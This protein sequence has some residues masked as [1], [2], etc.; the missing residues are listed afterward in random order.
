MWTLCNCELTCSQL[1]GHSSET[2]RGINMELLQETS[3]NSAN[4][5]TNMSMHTFTNSYFVSV[6][7]SRLWWKKY[8]HTYI[9]KFTIKQNSAKYKIKLVKHVAIKNWGN[10]MIIFLIIINNKCKIKLQM[11]LSII[12]SSIDSIDCREF[13]LGLTSVVQFDV[14]SLKI[15]LLFTFFL[16]KTLIS[17]SSFL[18]ML[19]HE[20]IEFKLKADFVEASTLFLFEDCLELSVSKIGSIFGKSF[21]SLWEGRFAE[22]LKSVSGFEAIIALAPF[23]K[24]L[25]GSRHVGQKYFLRTY[26]L[27]YTMFS[28]W[29]LMK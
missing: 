19:F 10:K 9:Y 4:T 11:A 1:W 12:N 2:S 8:V 6:V 17:K 3:W 15:R 13:I 24:N 21:S 23:F 29:W 26:R 28:V 14:K 18:L 16:F 27:F 25:W 5:L 20:W 22:A 7:K